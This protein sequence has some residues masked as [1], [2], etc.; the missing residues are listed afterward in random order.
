MICLSDEQFQQLENQLKSAGLE[1]QSLFNDLLDHYYCLT[2]SHMEKGHDFDASAMLALQEL[3]PN[4]FS[5]IE[6]ELQ[7]LF[8]FHFQ[9]SMKRLLYSGA[10]LATVGQTLYVLFK[11]LHWPGANVALLM[12][13]FGLFFMVIPALLIQFRGNAQRI[14]SMDKFRFY[15][16]LI[17][18][19]FFGLGSLFKIMHWPGANIQLILGTAILAF[20]FFPVYF[21]QQ[22]RQSVAQLA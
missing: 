10:L 18:I 1:R 4:G 5:A 17:G 14:N 7:F 20:M 2:T 19:S 9:I 6:K 13:V 3:A 21:W 11:N 15:A 22:Y 8:T 16:G 12:A